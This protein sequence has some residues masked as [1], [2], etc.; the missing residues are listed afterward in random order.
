VEKIEVI[1]VQ[2]LD[3][4]REGRAS[5]EDCL[6]RYSEVRSELESLLQVALSIKAPTGICPSDAFK[7]KARANL[8]NY[9]H[10][11]Q[12]RKKVKRS[13]GQ[14]SIRYWWHIAWARAT[15]IAVTVALA[16]SLAGTGTAYAAQ[17]S[18][19]GDTFYSV[20]LVIEQLQRII[21]FDDARE[22]EL[23][24]K[25]ADTRLDELEELVS[26]PVIQTASN[27]ESSNDVSAMSI[28]NITVAEPEVDGIA[29]A[30]RITIAID[31]YQRNL[32][33]AITKA[34]N[35]VEGEILVE[36]VALAILSHLSRL[37]VI[38]DTALAD[39]QDTIADTRGIAINGH[40]RI[41][42]ILATVNP[43]RATEINLLAIQARLAKA[44]AEAVKVNIRGMEDA[45]QEYEKLRR[46]GEGISN[47]TEMSGQDTVSIDELNARATTEHMESFGSIYG[48][49]SQDAKGAVEQAIDVAIETHKQAVQGLQQQGA[50]GDIPT[51]PPMPDNIPQGDTGNTQ[52]SES[53]N[54]GNSNK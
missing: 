42:Q 30:E 24:L 18:L 48:N 8:M 6:N 2:C 46:F 4:I 35:V 23:E 22:V 43:V 39:S 9:I 32:N 38:E 27:E 44:D 53:N 52:G 31:G 41:L 21:T 34:A 49:A 15:A 5:L 29:K 16:I 25:Y 45:L 20:K 50:Q 36:K 33:M 37:D 17:S 11:S 26:V 47:S 54:P 13:P 28:V 14:L 3:D 40:I 7:V 51:E 19:P 10:T 12:L 1:L